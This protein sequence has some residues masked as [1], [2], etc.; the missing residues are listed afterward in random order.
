MTDE[1]I[2]IGQTVKSFLP[3][4][5]CRFLQGCCILNLGYLEKDQKSKL[6]GQCDYVKDY[7]I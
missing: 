5:C 7:E 4:S 1:A 6:V 2:V 3:F